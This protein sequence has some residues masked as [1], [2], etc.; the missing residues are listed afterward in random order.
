M[1]AISPRWLEGSFRHSRYPRE[2]DRRDGG[3]RHIRMRAETAFQ[4]V[5]PN[6]AKQRVQGIDRQLALA[7]F[8]IL[9]QGQDWD[10]GPI[11]GAEEKAKE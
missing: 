10:H 1:A 11:G 2:E 8:Q 5:Q 3:L 6:I 7:R 4:L 9:G